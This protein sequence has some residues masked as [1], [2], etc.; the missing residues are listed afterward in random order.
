MQFYTKTNTLGCVWIKIVSN[1]HLL[2]R[3]LQFMAKL[4]QKCKHFCDY[5]KAE[6]SIFFQSSENGLIHW[7]M[8]ERGKVDSPYRPEPEMPA[9]RSEEPRQDISWT[10]ARGRGQCPQRPTA[11]AASPSGAPEHWK[12]ETEITRNWDFS[13]T[14]RGEKVN[15]LQAQLSASK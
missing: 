8:S 1:S 7:L 10:L 6:P 12:V 13:Q 9:S 11:P 4:A 15:E 2:Q 3:L 5:F 14:H